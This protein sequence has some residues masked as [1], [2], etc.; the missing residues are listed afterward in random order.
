MMAPMLPAA[1]A[2]GLMIENVRSHGHG[3]V[4][5]CPDY[6][7]LTPDAIFASVAPISAGVGATAMPAASQR[8]DLLGRGALAAGDDRA[9]V[10]HA[11][12]RAARS[13]RR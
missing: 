9:G 7:S 12:A 13:G 8:G 1:T 4:T 5:S 2:S 3:S 6:V 11:L 10:A